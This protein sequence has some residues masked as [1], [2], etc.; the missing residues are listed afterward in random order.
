MMNTAERMQDHR[1]K[2]AGR[3]CISLSAF[4]EFQV[5]ANICALAA[6]RS[7]SAWVRFKTCLHLTSL[8]TER[9]EFKCYIYKQFM[10]CKGKLIIRKQYPF[11]DFQLVHRVMREEK[12]SKEISPPMKEIPRRLKPMVQKQGHHVHEVQAEPK[13]LGRKWV[14]HER[15]L[16]LRNSG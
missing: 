5:L 3:L 14:N 13:E 9:V 12:T 1:N 4:H 16:C 15:R 7:S 8:D 6:P 2:A 11:A 10:K